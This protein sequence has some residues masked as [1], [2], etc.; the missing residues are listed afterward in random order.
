MTHW[1]E[2]DLCSTGKILRFAFFKDNK[3]YV[4]PLT[5]LLPH[6]SSYTSLA[7]SS[8]ASFFVFP[9][10]SGYSL[11]PTTKLQHLI[12][13]KLHLVYFKERL[14]THGWIRMQC[15]NLLRSIHWSLFYWL[16]WLY[17]H[18]VLLA[19]FIEPT[20]IVVL[21]DTWQMNWCRSFCC[22]VSLS[23]WQQ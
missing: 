6:I 21:N 15:E 8:L 19:I 18:L 22:I 23:R 5:V 12:S 10:A 16:L 9:V 14:I 13:H 7:A 2:F 11:S 4:F 17:K 3:N 20:Y 1:L